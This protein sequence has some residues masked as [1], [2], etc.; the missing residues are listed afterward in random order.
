MM[1]DKRRFVVIVRDLTCEIKLMPSSAATGS[2]VLSG[3]PACGLR[4]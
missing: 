2:G 3:R 4:A 1:L